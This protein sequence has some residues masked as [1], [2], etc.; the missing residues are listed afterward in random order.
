MPKIID[1]NANYKSVM[2][3][4]PVTG[5]QFA[6]ALLF[7]KEKKRKRPVEAESNVVF[8][9]TSLR[10]ETAEPKRPAKKA[11]AKPAAKAPASPKECVEDGCGKPAYAKGRCSRHYTAHRRQDPAVREAANEASRQY[12]LRGK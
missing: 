1:R 7:A 12:R 2:A 6:D 9:T 8:D 10:D 4:E 5:T 11:A 3:G